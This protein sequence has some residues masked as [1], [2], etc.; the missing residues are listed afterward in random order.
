MQAQTSKI[1]DIFNG[2]RALEI[3][4][5]QRSYVWGEPQWERMLEDLESI[6]ETK[7]PYFMGSVIL[8]QQPTSS[9]DFVGDRRTLIDGQQRLTTL[10]IVIKVLCLKT[11]E[12]ETFKRFLT[13]RNGSLALL[14]NYSDIK[15]FEQILNLDSL[16]SLDGNSPVLEAYE[17]FREH[18][19]SSKIDLD[20]VLNNVTFVGIDLGLEEDEQQIFD[21]INSLGVRLTTAELLKNYFFSRDEEVAFEKNWRVIF[22]LDDDVKKF[23]DR[24]IT[25]GRAKRENID[26][27]FYSFLQ[28]KIQDP[29]IGVRSEDK[30]VYSKV[31]GLFE[32][33]KSFIKNYELDKEELL[34]EIKTYADLY[35]I[36]IRHDIL[37]SELSSE[38]GIERINAIIFGL[39]NTTLIPY[40]LYVLKNVSNSNERNL[41][42]E[43][44]ETYIMRRMVCHMNN[45][46]Y[47][48]LF[49]EKLISNATTTKE[50]LKQQIESQA[51]THTMMPSDIVL[52]KG[53]HES[54]LVNKQATGILYLIESM[55][56]NKTK[57]STS[58]LGLSKYSLEHIMP[59]K[60]EN[61]WGH[62][63]TDE[64]RVFRNKK[65]LTLGNLTIITANLNASIRDSS[66]NKKKEGQSGKPGLKHY[67]SGIET[68]SPYLEHIE[69]NEETIESR[70]SDLFEH[71]KAIWSLD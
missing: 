14:H 28:I 50:A 10:N 7:R 15:D 20:A 54:W 60:W 61:N 56:R 70:A 8:K 32:S 23:W 38:Y 40:V 6:T 63:Q 21:T 27:F 42:W 52:E 33:Y 43:Y 12:N 16:V 62:V 66:W 58:M 22:E 44:L 59:K 29:E 26:L 30:K 57:Q 36:W 48:N 24:D 31:E 68:F 9:R 5:F 37:E 11:N 64:E 39:D 55:I 71:A 69:W 19:N 2:N 1:N 17:Y 67:S 35:R 65:L 41:I 51:E 53:F 13:L 49:S 4:F 25:A 46:N 3:P 47:N 34:A 45:K 18:L